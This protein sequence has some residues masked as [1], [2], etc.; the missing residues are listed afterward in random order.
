M[1]GN[2]PGGSVL[3]ISH[4][5]PPESGEGYP[6]AVEPFSQRINNLA[7]QDPL[8]AR[9]ACEAQKKLFQAT[10]LST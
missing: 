5:V 2:D 8:A 1:R 9:E 7:A 3:R 10:G 6:V 4:P